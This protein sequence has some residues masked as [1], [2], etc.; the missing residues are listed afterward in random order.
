MKY[1]SL[2]ELM[3]LIINPVISETSN[4]HDFECLFQFLYFKYGGRQ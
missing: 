4:K 1:K 3:Q 2:T